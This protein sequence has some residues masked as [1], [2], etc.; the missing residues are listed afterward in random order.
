MQVKN[1]ILLGTL[2]RYSDRFHEFQAFKSLEERL[3][4][5]TSIS[6]AHGVEP[7]YPQDIGHEGEQLELIKKADLPVSAVN[8]NVKGEAEFK[9]GAFTNPDKAVRDKTVTYLKTAMDI[10]VDLDTDMISVC[11][12]IDGFRSRLPSG[13]CQAVAVAHRGPNR[14]RL[15]PGRRAYL[16]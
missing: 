13:P 8:V 16:G 15:S 14:S 7:V 10:A 11:P 5:S 9:Y 1:S 6:R 4:L 2:G 12:L 3:E